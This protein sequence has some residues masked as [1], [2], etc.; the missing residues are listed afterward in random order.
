[1]CVVIAGS[2]A[3]RVGIL[4]EKE[5]NFV[6]KQEDECHSIKEQWLLIMGALKM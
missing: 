2:L 5:G 3:G 4:N 6:L 1:M